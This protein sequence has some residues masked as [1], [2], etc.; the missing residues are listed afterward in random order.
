MI[1]KRHRSILTF[2]ARNARSLDTAS[3]KVQETEGLPTT[4]QETLIMWN[5]STLNETSCV[6]SKLTITF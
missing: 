4:T 1:T 3:N 6:I 5:L 2:S